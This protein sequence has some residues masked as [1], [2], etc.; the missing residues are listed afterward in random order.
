M[1]TNSHGSNASCH[2]EA[3]LIGK[4]ITVVY[5]ITNPSLW[6][7][8]NP[9]NYEHDGVKAYCVSTGDIVERRDKLLE[10]LEKISDIGCG[11]CREIACAAIDVDSCPTLTNH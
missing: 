1:N 10:A 4:S 8:T 11:E 9:L 2:R 3:H 6:R 7:Q 5:E